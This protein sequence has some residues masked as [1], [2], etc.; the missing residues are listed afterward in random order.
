[1]L[2]KENSYFSFI[3]SAFFFDDDEKNTHTMKY[4]KTENVGDLREDWRSNFFW[5][6]LEKCGKLK[7]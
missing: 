5:G 7:N 4:K 1:M 2:N 3:V 6:R